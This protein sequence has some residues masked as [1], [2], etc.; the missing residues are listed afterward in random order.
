M[1]EQLQIRVHGGPALPTLVYLPGIHGDWTLAR[2]FKTA[3]ADRARW[4]EFTYPRTLDWTLG[5]YAR[6]IEQAL[7][8][9]QIAR[10]WLVGESFSSQAAWQLAGNF[11]E[12]G[13]AAGF[14]VEGI[15]LAGGFVRHPALWEVRLGHCFNRS[16]PAAA[17]RAI[18]ATLGALARARFCRE[19]EA[20]RSVRDFLERRTAID[21]RAIGHRF[22]IITENDLRSIARRVALPVYSLTALTDLTVPWPWVS[23]WLERNCPGYRATKILPFASHNVLCSAAQASADQIMEWVTAE[24][25]YYL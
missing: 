4:V 11:M 10:G 19:P 21:A 13:A 8:E 7:Q 12:R 1:S 23:R 9:N 24:T 6:A 3:L 22:R 15:I 14:R 5:D 2:C 25:R 18:L 17:R 20:L 16:M